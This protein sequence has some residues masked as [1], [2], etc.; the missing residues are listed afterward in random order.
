M[1]L[2]FKPFYE[3]YEFII[4]KIQ[5]VLRPKIIA[6]NMD[7]F[8]IPTTLSMSKNYRE[9]IPSFV[10]ELKRLVKN[11]M[12]LMRGFD[13]KVENSKL[14]AALRLITNTATTKKINERNIRKRKNR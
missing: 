11:F 13:D 6:S 1:L 3:W 7:Y 14:D 4:R 8:L 2:K 5:G 9:Q 12:N 10:F